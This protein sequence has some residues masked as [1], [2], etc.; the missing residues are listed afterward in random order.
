MSKVPQAGKGRV[1][2]WRTAGEWGRSVGAARRRYGEPA[3]AGTS[4]M[5][6]GYA[7]GISIMLTVASSRAVPL[8]FYDGFGYPE[9]NLNAVATPVWVVG[10]GSTTFEIAVSN[11]AALTGPAGFAPSTGRG[12]RRAPSGTARRSVLAFTPVVAVPGNT[13]YV[14]FLLQVV[15]PPTGTELIGYLDNNNTSQGAPQCGIFVAAGPRLG[16]GKK[17]SAPGFLMS[18]NLGPGTHLVVARYTFQSGNDAVD[19]WVD[20]PASTFGLMEPPPPIGGATGGSDP[21]QLEYFQI[22]TSAGAGSVMYL[23]EFRIGTRWAEVVPQGDGPGGG[24]G[25]GVVEGPGMEAVG[26]TPD[27]VVV[28]G[29]RGTPG[30]FVQILGSPDPFLPLANWMLVNY[31]T[32]DAGGRVVFTNPVCP[33]LPRA[34]YRLRVGD[35]STKLDPPSILMP[36]QRVTVSPGD[37]VRLSVSARGPLLQYLWFRNGEPVRGAT[38]SVLEIPAVQEEDAGEYR[39]MVANPGGYVISAPA[40]LAVANEPPR[41]LAEPVDQTTFEGGSVVFVVEAAGTEPLEYQ[42]YFSEGELLPGETNGV[43]S[44]RGVRADR[45]G[46][47]W[48]LVRN[49]FGSVRSRAALLQVEATPGGLPP[50]N[51]MGWAAFAGVTGG[52]H[53]GNTNSVIV[54]D[55]AAFRAA[56]RLPQPLHILVSGTIVSTENYTYVYGPN[57]TI[58]GLGTNA[59]F[60]GNLRIHATNLIVRNLHFSNPRSGYDTLTIDSGSGGTGRIV[61]VDH[62]TFYNAPDGALDIT[63]GADY[64]TVS[65]CKFHYAPAPPGQTTHEF[66][67]LIGSSDS[68]NYPFRVTFHHNWYGEGCRERMPS[69][70]FG[71]VHV[72]NNFYDCRY[73]NYCIRTRID[74][75]VLVE[76]NYFLNVQNPWE[77]YVTGGTPGKLRAVG[78]ILN[79]CTWSATWTRGVQLIPGEDELGPE[80]NPPPYP[81]VMHEAAAVPFY[82]QNYAGAGKWPFGP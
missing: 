11:L 81:Y 65:W 26:M 56:V 2:Q 5:M 4:A 54:T 64:V 31:G 35:S 52:N 66:V 70:R 74:A 69:V 79:N 30:G 48:V 29:S 55:Y 47:Y 40:T 33:A 7:V 82:V 12:V 46:P 45:A 41:I 75:E 34:Y 73:N 36:P 18:S 17:S 8:P 43:L 37:P 49:A 42:W 39:V 1:R 22:V 28:V 19:L 27:G 68:D 3:L 23:D 71:R 50:T 72:F 13:V 58:L 80:L 51:V 24:G 77:R 60:V 63:K 44:L 61:W 53:G 59:A 76:N 9:G 20:P 62:C 6:L 78:N 25:D 14:S 38:R 10:N 16:I 67:N 21:A 15:T 57:K 32:F